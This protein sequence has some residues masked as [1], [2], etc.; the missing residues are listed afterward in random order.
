M[1]E[2]VGL[3]SPGKHHWAVNGIF[4]SYTRDVRN[5]FRFSF[6]RSR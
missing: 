1:G 5:M 4:H 6:P 3:V 2:R